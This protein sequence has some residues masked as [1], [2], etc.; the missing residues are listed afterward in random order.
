MQKNSRQILVARIGVTA[1]DISAAV[2]ERPV[3]TL[4]VLAIIILM[5]WL[6]IGVVNGTIPIISI[7]LLPPT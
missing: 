6:V 2:R 1:R 3:S 7:S 5:A 4:I